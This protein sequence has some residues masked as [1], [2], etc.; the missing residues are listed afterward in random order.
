MLELLARLGFPVM[1]R[2]PEL[3][4]QKIALLVGPH[5]ERQA[6]LELTAALALRGPV[7]VLDGGNRFDPFFV[8]RAI[9]RRTAHLDEALARIWVARAFTCYQVITLLQETPSTPAPYL[10]FDLLATFYDEAVTYAESYRLLRLAV[11]ELYRFR[12][13]A[14]VIIGVRP[15]PDGQ[16]TGLVRFLQK[17]ADFALFQEPEIMPT[18]KRLF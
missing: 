2:L 4:G 18:L 17:A 13:H 11:K 14:P 5:A 12:Q 8:S 3:S 6:M 7:R 10:V 15:P 1:Q 9:R 16:R